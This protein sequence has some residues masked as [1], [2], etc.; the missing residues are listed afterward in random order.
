M[1]HQGHADDCV[2]C[3]LIIL[4][5]GQ[6]PTNLPYSS[7]PF[8]SAYFKRL[9]GALWVSRSTICFLGAQRAFDS[10]NSTP[11]HLPLSLDV[12]TPLPSFLPHFS[13]PLPSLLNL[14]CSSP[15][16]ISLQSFLLFHPHIGSCSFWSLSL[17]PILFNTSSPYSSVSLL[18]SIFHG[19]S[20]FPTASVAF[21]L[22]SYEV[23]WFP[24]SNPLMLFIAEVDPAYGAS[25]F[26]LF[27]VCCA[28]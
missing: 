25:V 12:P 15:P 13:W 23:R 10:L 7:L 8:C 24:T 4:N 27:C 19:S 17:P 18:S 14:I 20:S 26:K 11:L 6:S 21:F 16:F 3:A 28:Y 1:I 22:L 9:G 2:V 5:L